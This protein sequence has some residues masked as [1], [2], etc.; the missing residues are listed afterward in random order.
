M[1]YALLTNHACLTRLDNTMVVTCCTWNGCRLDFRFAFLLM[2]V[3]G[4]AIRALPCNLNS[5][6]KNI[7][8]CA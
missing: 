4:A 5:G 6:K 1:L 7:L 3:N 8:F 2:F